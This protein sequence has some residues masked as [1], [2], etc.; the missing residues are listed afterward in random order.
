MAMLRF[1]GCF[2]FFFVIFNFFVF[3]VGG[4]LTGFGIYITVEAVQNGL[5]VAIYGL[6]LFTLVLGLAVLTV[7]FIGCFGACNLNGCLIKWYAT[8]MMLLIV[9]EII[10]G[11]LLFALK[12]QSLKLIERY[13]NNSIYKIESGV[14]DSHLRNSIRKIQNSLKCC[15]AYGPGDWRDPYE[16]CCRSGKICF[17]APKLGCVQAAGKVLT[18]NRLP[19]GITVMVFGI[20]EIGAVACA[21]TL[22]RRFRRVGPRTASVT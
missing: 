6:P 8:L 7:A 13:F 11:A 12:N 3:V 1:S 14:G 20:I 17:R 16:F 2:R 4:L 19:L 21:A 18:E 22:E 9:G 5:I 15:G 10:C